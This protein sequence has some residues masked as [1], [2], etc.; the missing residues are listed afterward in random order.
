MGIYSK[1]KTQSPGDFS[2]N[3]LIEIVFVVNFLLDRSC[4][5]QV[6][7]LTLASARRRLGLFRFDLWMTS[8]SLWP[9]F[10]L[11]QWPRLVKGHSFPFR[12]RAPAVKNLEIQKKSFIS[13]VA[14]ME[15]CYKPWNLFA[16]LSDWPLSSPPLRWPSDF[17][18]KKRRVASAPAEN[19]LS[20]LIA[21]SSTGSGLQ[22]SGLIWSILKK[23]GHYSILAFC[24]GHDA[25]LFFILP[26]KWSKLCHT[27]KN[28]PPANSQIYIFFR[29]WLPLETSVLKEHFRK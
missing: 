26:V 23:K 27:W 20:N 5:R 1:W 28:S 13:K 9:H 3:L 6:L 8:G 24:K 10:L 29:E 22:K 21:S 11:D 17:R 7:N 25:H 18:N 4:H 12:I 15:Y 19:S 16:Q 2:H 14:R